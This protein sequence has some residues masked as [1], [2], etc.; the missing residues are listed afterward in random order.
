MTDRRR[1]DDRGGELYDTLEQRQLAQILFTRILG[2]SCLLIHRARL[3]FIL[4]VVRQQH[5]LRRPHNWVSIAD[6]GFL[7]R[8]SR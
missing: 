8:V 2:L 1:E 7:V 6:E 3:P 4:H 5:Y